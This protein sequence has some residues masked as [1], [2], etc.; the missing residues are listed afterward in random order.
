MLFS[1]LFNLFH[2]QLL[3]AVIKQAAVLASILVSAMFISGNGNFATRKLVPEIGISFLVLVTGT[4]FLYV[5]HGHNPD[6]GHC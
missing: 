1:T 2:C 4:I 5:C 6:T 3:V